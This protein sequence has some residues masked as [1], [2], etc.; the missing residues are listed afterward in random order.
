MKIS[1]I[2]AGI[3]A[4]AVAATLAISASAKTT[5]T[6]TESETGAWVTCFQKWESEG[7]SMDN[8]I[9]AKSFTKDTPIE[10]TINYDLTENFEA[11]GYANIK[12]CQA[13]QGWKALSKLDPSYIQGLRTLNVDCTYD[14]SGV[15]YM[16]TG[17]DALDADGNTIVVPYAMQKAGDIT[18]NDPDNHVMK[19][20]ISA[21]CVNYLVDSATETEASYNGIQFQVNNIKVNS[22]ELSQDG[23]KMASTVSGVEAPGII[24]T[25]DSGTPVDPENPD[26]STPDDSTPDDSTTD[27][28]TDSDTP[29]DSTTDG[30]SK[31]DATTTDSSKTDSSSK[32]TTTTSTS[33]KD[34]SPNT[35]VA[36]VAIAGLALAGAALVATKK[37]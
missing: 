13:A 18:T 8:Y 33:N 34:A 21:D 7:S 29:A 28:P 11:D 25:D 24:V 23:I 32:P 4:M 3:S 30:T 19:F 22:I 20:T 15:G 35:G 26:D 16:Y 14:V 12:P 9:D 5:I 6:L 2:L 27:E 10:V 1:K 17:D 36:A 31:P 37:K